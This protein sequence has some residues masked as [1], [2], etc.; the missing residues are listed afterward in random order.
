MYPD[1]NLKCDNVLSLLRDSN[2]EER[3]KISA[4]PQ[5]TS[6]NVYHRTQQSANKSEKEETVTFDFKGKLMAVKK[7]K[8]SQD[9]EQFLVKP[10]VRISVP[11][12]KALREM[13]K[14]SSQVHRKESILEV[15]HENLN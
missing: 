6:S 3:P 9:A 8:I 10:N 12:R 1:R 4:A 14:S 13:Q 5:A 2:D 11:S 7:T 15:Y